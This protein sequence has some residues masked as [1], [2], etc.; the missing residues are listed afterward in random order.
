MFAARSHLSTEIYVLQTA[1]YFPLDVI[2]YYENLYFMAFDLQ[3]LKPEIH[4]NNIYNPNY[5][6]LKEKS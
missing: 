1:A 2:L 4:I 5:W 6:Y 3:A